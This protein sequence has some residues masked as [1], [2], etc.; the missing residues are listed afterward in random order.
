MPVS[1]SVISFCCNIYQSALKI[2]YPEGQDSNLAAPTLYGS[3]V[4]STS[5]KPTVVKSTV[6]AST[7]GTYVVSGT[8]RPPPFKWSV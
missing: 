8:H 4:S 7:P 3:K 1:P 2:H 5:P 6:L